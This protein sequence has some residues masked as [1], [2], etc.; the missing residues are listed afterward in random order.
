MDSLF[1]LKTMKQFFI[2]LVVFLALDMLWLLVIAKSFYAKHLGYLLAEK[3][4][5]TAALVFYLIFIAGMLVFVVQPAL[6]AGSWQKALTLGI[7]FGLVTYS[8][9]DLTNH[10]TI[11]DWP[12]L[13]TLVDIT[14]GCV[15]GALTATLGYLAIERLL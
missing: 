2:L 14:W 11:R 13:V 6:A 12:L 7:F 4:N 1:T 10:A 15:L 8:T 5:L 9:Y 3:P